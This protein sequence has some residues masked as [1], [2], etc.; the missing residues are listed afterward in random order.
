MM[1]KIAA[2]ALAAALLLAAVACGGSS[3]TGAA[4]E[5]TS[6]P[7]ADMSVSEIMSKIMENVDT[8]FG[9]GEIE[10]DAD[11]LPYYAFVDYKDGY[12]AVANEAMIS[13]IAHSVVLLRVPE[14]EDAAAVAA[15]VNA[16][17][18]PAKW[19]CVEAEKTEVVQNGN[20][21]LLVMSTESVADA[22]VAGFNDFC[23]AN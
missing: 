11:S 18:D 23:G 6:N 19:V 9:T 14:S 15:E 21:I 13:A 8:E 1:K 20:L 4:E 22:V 2:L 5:S 12:E 17:A 16:N 3:G 10:L 7:G